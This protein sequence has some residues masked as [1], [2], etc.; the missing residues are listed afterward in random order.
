MKIAFRIFGV[1]S[2]YQKLGRSSLYD[3]FDKR[4]ESQVNC[5]EIANLG[6]HPKKQD[7]NLPILDNYSH[8]RDQLISKLQKIREV[9]Q[10]LF[11]SIV[12]LIL[13]G[14][15]EALAHQLHDDRPGG[16]TVSRQ[17]TNKLMKVY[18]DWT[19]KKGTAAASKLPLN[20]LEEELNM[21]YKV[22]YIAKFYSISSSFAVDSDQTG[23]HL[24]PAVGGKTWNAKGTKNVKILGME[25]K[26]QITCVMYSSGSEER[27]PIQ[28]I[29][30]GKTIRCLPKQSDG[31]I[32]YIHARWQ[33]IFFSKS[34]Q[35]T[36]YLLTICC[37][38]FRVLLGFQDYPAQSSK[39]TEVNMYD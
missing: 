26:R 32:K 3:W 29:F 18:I 4:G 12:Q 15:F 33:F 14:M 10:I 36:S 2:L 22:A 39:I 1:S 37:R 16:F 7:Q 27:L 20:W 6:H 24:I 21:N 35:Y 17:W 13:R 34:L 9:G 38:D 19:I 31:N 23:I 8:V 5:K 30:T 25:D 28:T 11:I